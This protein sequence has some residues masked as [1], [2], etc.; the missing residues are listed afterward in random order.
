MELGEEPVA[1][2]GNHRGLMAEVFEDQRRA[3]SNS[4]P[5]VTSL[6]ASQGANQQ[7]SKQGATKQAAEERKDAQRAVISPSQELKASEKPSLGAQLGADLSE[8]KAADAKEKQHAPKASKDGEKA[9]DQSAA[10]GDE[11]DS[12]H[13]LYNKEIKVNQDEIPLLLLELTDIAYKFIK[14]DQFEKAYVLLQKT[15]S[16]LEVVNL[17][18]SK[19]DRYFA[20]ITYLN[21]AMCF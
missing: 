15:E 16:V 10:D 4:P 18:H 12:F 2:D 7:S 5:L 21:M 3:N 1:L 13:R 6:H 20:Y 17:E 8:L 11:N 9:V 14:K 19:R